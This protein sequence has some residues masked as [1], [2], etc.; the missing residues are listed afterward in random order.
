MAPVLPDGR[1]VH[2]N[3]L[4]NRSPPPG[5]TAE[6]WWLA[7][8]LART[9][10]SVPLQ[11]FTGIDDQPFWFCRLDAIDRV[12]HEL[13]RRD[14]AKEIIKALGD[15]ASQHQYRTD[16]LI[17]EAISSSVLEGAKLTTR[18][19]AKALIRDGRPPQS[20]G[21]RMVVNNYQAMLRLIALRDRP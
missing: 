5:L 3:D 19:Q 6:H 20:R 17:E 1:Y 11:E 21:E 9:V 13:D 4:R 16:Q 12:T 10:G 8:K 2:W 7:Q 14:A 15:A 18:A